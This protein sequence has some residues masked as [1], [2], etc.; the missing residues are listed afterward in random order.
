MVVVSVI[1]IL[2]AIVYANF[3]DARKIARDKI[4][5][6]DLKDLQVAIELFKAQNGRYP[7]R[8]LTQNDAA[9][10]R[11]TT[12]LSWSGNVNGDAQCND[13]STMYIQ[14]LVPDYIAALPVDPLANTYSPTSNAGYLYES[15]SAGTAYK[16]LAYTTVEKLFIS[17]YDDEFA[18]CP[19]GYTTGVSNPCQDDFSNANIPKTY[20]VYK[21][22][23]SYKW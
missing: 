2:S 17:S 22:S 1:G 9:N 23:A 20:A 3:G 5:Q 16:L 4:R 18:R 14:G 6:T 13:G 8:C 21:N 12:S 7:Y 19:T 11:A 10:A 15:N